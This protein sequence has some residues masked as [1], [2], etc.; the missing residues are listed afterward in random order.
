[1][2]YLNFRSRLILAAVLVPWLIGGPSAIGQ[3]Q[4][5]DG[6]RPLFN[7]KNLDGWTQRGGKAEYTIED[8]M[9]VGTSVPNTPNSFL[10]T[11]QLYGN[12]VLEFDYKVDPLLNSGVQIRSLVYDED[13]TVEVQG[14]ER[15]FRAGV[16]HGYQV[17]IDPSDRAWS[18]GIY[19]ESR[20]GWL[21]NLQ[22]NP[23][24][25]A[26]FRQNEW[27]HYRIFCWGDTIQTWINGVPAANL[28]DA[29]TAKG[30]IGLQVHGVGGD[31]N[32]VGKQVRW[33]N[34]QIKELRDDVVDVFIGTYTGGPSQGIYR[35]RLDL[36]NGTLSEP[37]L[38]A[39]AKNPSF[40]A[41]HPNHRWLYAVSEISDH[42]GQ[43][44]GAVA[45]YE[46]MGDGSL[47]LINQQASGGAGPCHLIVDL[48]GQNV[49]V[50]NY[51]GG[52]VACLP[53]DENGG[54]KPASDTVQ[55]KGSS[56]NARRQEAP[57]A[58][59]IN[60]DFNNRFA[61]VADLGI[62]QVLI[63]EFDPAAGSL[64]PSAPA[65]VATPAGGG[66]RH[67]AL[68][69]SRKFAYTNNELTSTVTAFTFSPNTGA[70]S[71]IDTFSTLPDDFDGENTTAELVVHPNGK[72]VYCSNRGH[73]SI[74][75]FQVDP[76]TGKLT[77]VSNTSTQGEVPRNFAID[78]SGRILL[79]ENQATHSVVAFRID[80]ETGELT[81][82]GST[83]EV[84]S[85]VCVRFLPVPKANAK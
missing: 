56:V 44:T 51:G 4:S 61:Y 83:I 69:P 12:F 39:E 84:G 71:V 54:L 43:K 29:V 70:L 55:H 66:P 79:A 85:P 62:D 45:A 58:H 23:R 22:N 59:S 65:S 76:S 32:K 17:E 21:Y 67:F 53:I 82:T 72:F 73:N 26:A 60:L 33:K 35:A 78:P 36:N 63:Y 15:R 75:L 18:A 7:G 49:L 8:D 52:S 81:P 5:N 42:E 68:H 40:V 57:H 27:N 28:R 64:K 34:L 74:A 14:K 41:I 30:L 1:M 46:I 16:V 13:R 9:I 3:T 80:A 25:R 11:D 10:C 47:K 6:F 38:A 77:R 24:A 20:R 37:K 50:A 31:A 2:R 19:D 48:G